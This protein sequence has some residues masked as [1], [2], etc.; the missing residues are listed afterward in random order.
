MDN[1][2]PFYDFDDIDGSG[3]FAF[4]QTSTSNKCSTLLLLFCLSIVLVNNPIEGEVCVPGG[5]VFSDLHKTIWEREELSKRLRMVEQLTE[6]FYISFFPVDISGVSW[7]D[8]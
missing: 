2:L 3:L 8:W 5:R 7:R 6:V 1:G 4:E